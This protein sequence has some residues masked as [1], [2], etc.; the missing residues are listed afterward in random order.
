MNLLSREI[1][2]TSRLLSKE[3]RSKREHTGWKIESLWF[4]DGGKN[5]GVV[6]YVAC[7]VIIE[8]EKWN[9]IKIQKHYSIRGGNIRKNYFIPTW[10]INNW[11]EVENCK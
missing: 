5:E 4:K 2:I 7:T 11:R 9:V 8:K 3:R 6:S 10:L 1:N